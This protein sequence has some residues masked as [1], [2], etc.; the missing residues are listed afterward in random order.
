MNPSFLAF[1]GTKSTITSE[2]KINFKFLKTQNYPLILLYHQE[3]FQIC[4]ISV[5]LK[6]NPTEIDRVEYPLKCK[7]LDPWLKNICF[8][9]CRHSSTRHRSFGLDRLPYNLIHYLVLDSS[10]TGAHLSMYIY[11]RPDS[12][13]DTLRNEISLAKLCNYRTTAG[14]WRTDKRPARP[15]RAREYRNQWQF[16]ACSC[17]QYQP[18]RFHDFQPICQLK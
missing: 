18:D 5:P 11:I 14:Q 16:S 4:P 7:C 10:S 13:A 6:M 3:K 15:T 1:F 12:V 17:C 9:Y 2:M 8:D